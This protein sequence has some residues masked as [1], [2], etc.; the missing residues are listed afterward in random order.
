MRNDPPAGEPGRKESGLVGAILAAGLG[1]R[2]GPLGRRYPKALL[3]VGDLPVIGHH[4][5]LLRS[6][7]LRRV[8]VVTRPDAADLH[9]ACNAHGAGLEVTFV[10]QP[11]ALGS[12]HAAG[13]LRPYIDGPFVLLLG[14]YFFVAPRAGT[15][16]ARLERGEGAAIAAKR[17]PDAQALKEACSLEVTAG[18]RVVDIVEK[19]HRPRSDLKG[20]GFYAL[21][22]DFFEFLARTPRTALRDEYELSVSLELYLRAG[23]PLFAEEAVAWDWNLTRPE[24]VLD[25]NLNWL[26]TCGL[27]VLVSERAVVDRSVLLD[28]VVVGDR[29]RVETTPRLSEVVVF[30]D[31]RVS[32]SEPIERAVITPE[33]RILLGPTA[34]GGSS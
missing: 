25:C 22:S 21:P 23:R 9:E 8:F 10:E 30:P 13:C 20:C 32:S 34:K 1:R 7:G 15:L 27:R 11:R 29:A 24:D 17:E 2:M 31:S 5:A 16:V 28:R 26:A 18:G 6:L 4:L 33:N 3:P 12:A 19:P 14:D